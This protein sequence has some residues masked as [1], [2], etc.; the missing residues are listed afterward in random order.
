M[1]NQLFTK[2]IQALAPELDFRIEADDINTLESLNGKWLPSKE[3]ILA[4]V[5][6]VKASIESDAIA[7][8][9]AKAA[10]LERLGITADEAAL[11]L[12]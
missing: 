7:K 9:A 10:L 5:E 6:I 3:D 1:S 8:A 2:A 11:L 4:Q 12:G